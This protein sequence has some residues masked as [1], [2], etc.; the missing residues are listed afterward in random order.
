MEKTLTETLGRKQFAADILKGLQSNPKTLSSK[1]F[2]DGTGSRLFQQIMELPEY[3]LTRTETEILQTQRH[4]IIFHLLKDKAA[5]N[6][7]DLGAG[8]AIK[9]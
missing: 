3:Y 4:E 6:L 1:Y 9:T 5:F 2:Y 7:I 8:D